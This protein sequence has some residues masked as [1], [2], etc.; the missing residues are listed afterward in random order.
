[1]QCLSNDTQIEL[2]YNK[3]KSQ[4]ENIEKEICVCYNVSRQKDMSN[5]FEQR[6]NPPAVR[7]HSRGILLNFYS[8]KAPTRLFVVLMATI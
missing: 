7:E 2:L 3:I 8:G 4:N 6:T 5:P 1:M